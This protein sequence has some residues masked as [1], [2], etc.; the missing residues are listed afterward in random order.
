M[1]CCCLTRGAPLNRQYLPLCL[2]PAATANAAPHQAPASAV[3]SSSPIC[4]RPSQT[5]PFTAQPMGSAKRWVVRCQQA[6]Q[7]RGRGNGWARQPRPV[8]QPHR[9]RHPL[10]AAP[11]ALRAVVLAERPA[12]VQTAAQRWRAEV[13]RAGAGHQM[14]GRL[15]AVHGGGRVALRAGGQPWLSRPEALSLSSLS[16]AGPLLGPARPLLGPAGP[17]W[18]LLGPVAGNSTALPAWLPTPCPHPSPARAPLQCKS[19]GAYCATC[20]PATLVC[21]ACQ[22]GYGFSP[23]GTCVRCLDYN[24]GGEEG[25]APCRIRA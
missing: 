17:Y 20:H 15:C 5:L 12:A 8:R 13:R 4:G 19:G 9:S 25:G 2:L 11:A 21:R 1:L 22:E 24:C 3:P 7:H 14:W 6:G 23:W 10:L 16:P 18:D